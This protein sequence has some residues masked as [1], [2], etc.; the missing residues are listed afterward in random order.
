M[1]D[2]AT[3]QSAQVA[4]HAE[5]V[6]AV[7]WV[8]SPDGGYLVTGSWDKTMKVRP[9]RAKQP[10]VLQLTYTGRLSL[11]YWDLRSANPIATV[12]L[13]ERCYSLDVSYPL[14]AVGTADRGLHSFDL[15]QPT[16][17]QQVCPL[18]PEQKCR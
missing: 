7:R 14:L 11:Q 5:P 17:P 15:R 18:P 8:D 12:Q 9:P 16:V 3:G 2:L 6:K 4:Q 13:P 1:Y 10:I